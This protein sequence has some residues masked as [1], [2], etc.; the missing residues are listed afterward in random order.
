MM[1]AE[2]VVDAVSCS[3]LQTAL[4]AHMR[5]TDVVLDLSRVERLSSPGLG[6]LIA[7]MENGFFSGNR[8][9]IMRPSPIVRLAMESSGFGHFFPVIE[10]PE[11]AD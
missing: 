10:R 4:L 6:A 7:A 8:L 3:A 9:F 1:K 5:R 11:D 2:G